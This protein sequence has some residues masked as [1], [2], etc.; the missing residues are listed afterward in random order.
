LMRA[1][2]TGIV[3]FAGSHLASEL[4]DS[5]YELFGTRLPGESKERLRGH[6]KL[7]SISSVD[8]TDPAAAMKFVRRVKP[9]VVFHLAAIS[10]VGFSFANPRQTF[11]VN[12]NG[13]VSLLEGLRHVGSAK[14]IVTVTSSDIYGVVKPSDLPIKETTP[15][16]PVTPYGVSKAA[17]DMLSYQYF[18]SYGLPIVRARA[19]NHTGPMQTAGFVV[20]DF[21]KQAAMMEAGLMKPVL[22][23]GNLDP[24]RDISDVRDIVRG[25][26]LIAEKGKPGEVYNLCS[27][28]SHRIEW[29]LDYILNLISLDVKVVPDPKLARPSE[30]PN[31][32]GDYAK[33][34]RAV[35][36]RP[37]FELTGTLQ[38]TL[39]YWR[40]A[41]RRNKD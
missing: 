22:K 35:G 13:T 1:L 39:S 10:A 7:I 31:L 21:C 32:I 9:D 2:V 16:Q 27:G 19:F 4:L 6:A 37:M 18:K 34:K 12:V 5:G 14:S 26:R 3:G 23:V 28:K 11:E 33:A 38:D 8:L 41:V 24:K 15:L 25:Y 17:V 30:I 20:P 36:Y 29:I 40:K